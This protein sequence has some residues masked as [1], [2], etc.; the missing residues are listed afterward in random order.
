MNLAIHAATPKLEAFYNYYVDHHSQSTGTQCGSWVDWY[1][2][3]VCDVET[4]AQL[5]GKEA[6]DAP[7]A[8]SPQPRPQILTFDH[9]FPP[10]Q[11]ILERP[12]RTAIFYASLTSPNFLELHTYLLKV[13]N[14]P[15]P[16]VEYVFRHIP[17]TTPS[18]LKNYLSGYGVAL[19]LKKMDYLAL[20]DR[21]QGT[22]NSDANGDSEL[23]EQKVDPLLP[24]ILAHPENTT[25]PGADVPLTEEEIESLGGKA[26]QLIAESKSPLT[27][28][29]HL[30]Q[31]F[32]KY[33]TSLARRVVVNE[34]ISSELQNNSLKVQRGASV[35]W[36]NGL[37]IELKDLHPFGLLKA[38]RKERGIMKW[39]TQQGLK[40]QQAF[41]V[42]THPAISATQKES[43]T[44]EAVFDASDREE[45]EDVIV[46]WNDMEKDS[47][48]ARWNPS[49]YSLLR[50][51]YPGAMPTVR[52]NL[53]NIVLIL[54][55]SDIVNLNFLASPMSNIINH[56]PLR[57]GLVPVTETDD[58]KR[59]AKLFYHLIKNYGRKKTLDVFRTMI[60]DYQRQGVPS[61]KI[62]WNIVR[63]AYEDLVEKERPEKPEADFPGLDTIIKDNNASEIDGVDLG[64]NE[65]PINEIEK[66]TQRL[67]ATLSRSPKGHVFFNGKHFDFD[68]DFFR[69]MQTEMSVQMNYLSEKIYSGVLS[70]ENKPESMSN[71]FYDLPTTSKRRNVYMFPPGGSKDVQIVSLPE[72]FAKT[73]FRVSPQTYLYPTA[74]ESVYESLYIVT[75]LDTQDG[76]AL[77]KEAISSLTSD[78]K[79]RV[80]FIHNPTI[81]Q[82]PESGTRP[83]ASWLI[84]HLH[85]R[86]LLS[87]ATPS[88]LISALGLEIS[89]ATAPEIV[90]KEEVQTA[91]K[92]NADNDLVFKQL[93][94]GAGLHD[95]L[96]EEYAD[97][98]KESKNVARELRLQPGQT[99]VVVNGRVVGPIPANDFRVADFKTLEDFEFRKR[100]EPVLKALQEVAPALLEDKF[101]SAHLVSMVS[102][103]VAAAQQ[104]DPSETGLFD[105]PPRPRQKGYLL[106]DSNYTSFVY[107]DNST[108]LYHVSVLLDPLSEIGQKWS[109]LLKWLS[110][111]P[112]IFIEVHL[113][114]GRY[115]DIPLKRF[116]RYNLLPAL[117]FDEEGHEIPAQVVFEDI[118]VDPIYTLAMDVPTAWLVR[119]RESLYDL[120]NIQLGKLFH[121]DTAVEAIFEL[122]YI[123]I[124]GHAREVPH[125]TVP[126]GVQLQLVTS[127]NVPIDDTQV[128]ANLGYFQFKAKPGVFRLEIREGKGRDIFKLESVGNEGWDSP[129]VEEAGA[130]ITVTSFEGSTLYPRFKRLPE[131]E[132]ADVLE[133]QSEEDANQKGVFEDL[134]SKVMSIFRSPK[135]EPSTDIVPVKP[136]AD[137]NI[138]TV[139]SGLLYERFVGIMILS[140]LRNTNSTVKFWFIE[141]FLSP[142]FLEFIPHMA[143]KYNFQYELVTYKWPSWLRA[144]TEKQRIIWAYKILFLDVLFPMDLKKVI[145][146]D[147]D[148][149]V[150][151]DL[152]ELVDLDLHGAPYGYTPMGDDNEDMEGFR[153]W[154]TGYWKEFLQ[155]KPYHISALYV[156][157]LVRFRQDIL[158][159]QYQQLSADP[160]SLA[161]L[162]QGNY[163]LPEDWL[164]CE[165]WCSKDRFHRAKTIDLCQNPLTKEPKLARARQIPENCEFTRELAAQGKIHS[166]LAVADVNALAGGGPALPITN[167]ELEVE[168]IAAEVEAVVEEKGASDSDEHQRDE[169]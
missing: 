106:L 71:Y 48:Y 24:L 95:I 84:A 3:V 51:L 65:A 108:A 167:E 52:A 26:A 136:Q 4:L 139:A 49:L 9:I 126:R 41:D 17:P 2:E 32:P 75:D 63:K 153:F 21:Q 40:R 144:Q 12:P 168:A 6:I 39:L 38:I 88:Q 80:S 156:I 61:T 118:P 148:Q 161:N 146:V 109:S 154:K 86:G 10:P 142:S 150:R 77:I 66:Y 25:A 157:D 92:E 165:T 121:G 122:D 101:V 54:D 107:G 14:R 143:E 5:T 16:H 57:F 127:D 1:G 131:M 78:S 134:S 44:L 124:E 105:T 160:N 158:R 15:D 82:S 8:P 162:D 110:S 98:V 19:D 163:S 68:E 164:W 102:S 116:Y 133:E 120:D 87:Q 114:P 128:V 34:S 83:P 28:L 22:S 55:L 129:T 81:I 90:V 112:D 130:H 59:M 151:A 58:A 56:I 138:F 45:G 123:V 43:G 70:D 50:P 103:V 30:S 64:T 99:A 76:L 97:Y 125:N 132:Q 53:F 137:I 31:N 36:L 117:A 47:R 35:F 73:R 29:T 69:Y 62:E 85:I 141:N 67:A 140:V 94:G 115:T 104:P 96:A 166:R 111:I 152:K 155:G 149:I 60:L 33:A 113:N 135:K 119:P 7:N 13:T 159:G 145:F 93:T 11:D 91:L 79:T 89:A 37:T 23:E 20:D 27:T 100:T 18:S 147:A 46:W 42:L 74:A 72:V 169:L